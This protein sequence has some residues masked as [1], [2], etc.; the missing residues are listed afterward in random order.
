MKM[1]IVWFDSF[2]ECECCKVKSLNKSKCIKKDSSGSKKQ[3]TQSCPNKGRALFKKYHD[4]KD[5][6]REINKKIPKY[7]GHAIY[8]GV[9]GQVVGSA[10]V[11]TLFVAGGAGHF[12]AV[13]N[14]MRDPLR[15]CVV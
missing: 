13:G 1:L 4:H 14:I 7:A 3:Q 8:D 11:S 15:T 12:G 6:L 2:Q 5:V 10:P 9:L